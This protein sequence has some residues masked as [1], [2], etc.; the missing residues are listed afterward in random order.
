MRRLLTSPARRRVLKRKRDRLA[1]R[2]HMPPDWRQGPQLALW[3]ELVQDGEQQAGVELGESVQSYLVFVLMRY[4]RDGAL[5]AHVLAL[6]WLA[7]AQQPRD[8]RANALRDVGDRCLLIAGCFPGLAE[9][10]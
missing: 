2:N 5:G 8:A 10:R 9:R 7:A 4:L 6:D 3:Q 1:R